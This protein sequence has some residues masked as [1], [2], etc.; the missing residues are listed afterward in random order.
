MDDKAIKDRKKKIHK[1]AKGKT[2]IRTTFWRQILFNAI[3]IL[4][5]IVVV[6]WASFELQDQVPV[7]ILVF[8]PLGHFI[9]LIFH[10]IYYQYF[11]LW[12]DLLYVHLDLCES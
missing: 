2:K 12:K 9:G 7:S 4:E 8:V 3:F 5:N 6:I 1:E 11:H 10:V